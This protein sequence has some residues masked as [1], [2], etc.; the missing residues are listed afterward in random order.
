MTGVQTCALPILT[1]PDLQLHPDKERYPDEWRDVRIEEPIQDN[2]LTDNPC[3]TRTDVLKKQAVLRV[4]RDVGVLLNRKVQL[5]KELEVELERHKEVLR[6][7]IERG[8]N[9]EQQSG[10]ILN[11]YSL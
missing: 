5:F 8:H 3:A 10:T 7:L 4:H 2:N 11:Y 9:I 1:H 6:T